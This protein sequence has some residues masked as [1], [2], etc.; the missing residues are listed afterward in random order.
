VGCAYSYPVG[1]TVPREQV[2]GEVALKLAEALAQRADAQRRV[3][4]LRA[5]AVGNARYQEG[6]KPAE[7]AARLIAEAEATLDLLPALPVPQLRARA[8]VLAREIRELDLRVQRVNW[9]A[10]LLD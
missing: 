3:E 6:E 10:D 8:D 1:G 7:D 2:P 5:R 9:E 4:Q